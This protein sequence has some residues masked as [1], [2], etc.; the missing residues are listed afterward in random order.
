MTL[1]NVSCHKRIA[2]PQV[3]SILST[4]MCQKRNYVLFRRKDVARLCVYGRR[5]IHDVLIVV[6]KTCSGR[7]RDHCDRTPPLPNAHATYSV[8]VVPRW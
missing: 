4:S 8:R 3:Q 1:K 5:L 2:I 6:L 7:C